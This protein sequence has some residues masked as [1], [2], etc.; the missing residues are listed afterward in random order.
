[1]ARDATLP[2]AVRQARRVVPTTI[3]LTYAPLLAAACGY[4]L[5]E[6]SPSNWLVQFFRFL[7]SA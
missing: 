4:R 2:V 1:L 7:L 3:R 5:I 6:V